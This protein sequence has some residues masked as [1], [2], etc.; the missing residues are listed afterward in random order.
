MLAGVKPPIS[1][2]LP[3]LPVSDNPPTEA[4]PADVP[5]PTQQSE[6]GFEVTQTVE[7]LELRPTPNPSELIENQSLPT[8]TLTNGEIDISHL[9]PTPT[10]SVLPDY[11]IPTPTAFAA[12]G[13]NGSEPDSSAVSRIVIPSMSLD[14]I[15]KYVPFNGSTWLISGLKQE[16]AWMGDTSWPGLGGNTGLAGHVDLVTGEKGPFW[17]LRNLRSG[18]EVKL[19]TAQRIYTYRVSEQKVVEDTDLTVIQESTKPKLTLITCTGWN[20]QVRLYLQRLV[21]SAELINM[22]PLSSASN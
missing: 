1:T 15:V 2:S 5:G 3:V 4:A 10:P 12:V 19:Y 17:N 13:P 7:L 9:L 14:A 6:H 11:P 16:V 8:P 21:V 22:Q 18:D 20:N